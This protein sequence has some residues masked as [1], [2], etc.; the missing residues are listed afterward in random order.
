MEKY[1]T[2]VFLLVPGFLALQAAT[3]LGQ[4]EKE[5]KTEYALSYI[6]FGT[7]GNLV[8]ISIA[9]LVGILPSDTN[10]TIGN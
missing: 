6:V 9:V 2:V 10:R 3:I 1:L 4:T 5:S 8:T 7:V